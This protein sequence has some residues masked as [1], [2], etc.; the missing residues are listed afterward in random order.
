LPTAT[1]GRLRRTLAA[2]LRPAGDNAALEARLLVAH[3]VGRDAATLPLAD[4]AGIDREEEARAL[5]YAGRRLAGE[6]VARITGS[7]EFWGLDFLLSPETLV[8]RPD[9]E[10]VVEAALAFAK[11]AG[12][13]LTI[14]DL[15]TG[16]GAILVALLSEL[17]DAEGVGVDRSAGAA[18]MASRNAER[19]G[20][21]RRASFLVGDWAAA[22]AGPFDIVVSNP[23]YIESGVIET[24][25]VD[26][27]G[28]DPYIA[29]DG[30]RDGLEA[31][32]GIIGGLDR[33]L[34][35]EGRAF[36]EI[37]AGQGPQIA[38][39]AGQ[40]GFA[41]KFR[42]DLASIERVAELSWAGIGA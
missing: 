32:R 38:A 42:R 13:P 22:L 28:Y 3:A 19:M 15:G 10:T 35:A 31:Y 14:L 34:E 17:P 5:A 1:I 39:M 7:K 4:D 6:P 18:A 40:S 26:V 12:R 11:S 2:R 41:A 37:G 36:L 8:P 16:S 30:G 33:V 23:P 25:P 24:L 27:K 20:L 9:T 21:A 29:L